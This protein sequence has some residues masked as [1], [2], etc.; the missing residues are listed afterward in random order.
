MR[1]RNGEVC[2]WPNLGY[3]RFGAKV[4]MDRAPWFDGPDQ[5]EQSRI[6]LADIDGSGVVDIIYFAAGEVRLYFNE[7]G[8]RWSN[9]RVL[10]VSRDRSLELSAS[11]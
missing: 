2:Y 3:G 7:S 6:R 4:T 9:A 11:C 1:I 10:A 8:N 5:F